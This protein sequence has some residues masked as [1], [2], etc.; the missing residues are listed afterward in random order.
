MLDTC[1]GTDSHTT[2]VNA[3][4]VLGW[5][6]GGIE[7]IS[8]ALGEPI[9]FPAPEVVGVHLR[10][11]LPAG[12]TAT[13]LVLHL[14][15]ALRREGVVGAFVEFHGVGM[16]GLPLETRATL[17]NMAPEYGSTC[18]YFPIDEETLRYLRLTGR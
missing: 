10:G 14:T 17:A 9:E 16:A 2:M 4:G 15:A 3:L 18:A 12:V 5:G 1:V 13:D 11:K 8:A 6:V 7:A